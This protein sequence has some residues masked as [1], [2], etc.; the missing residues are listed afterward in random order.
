MTPDELRGFN[1]ALA[2]L[3]RWGSQIERNGISLGGDDKDLVPRNHM[4]RHGGK[5]VRHCAEALALTEGK[6][7]LRDLNPSPNASRLLPTG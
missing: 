6:R 7:Q 4:M 5:M 2:C 3:M 1:L